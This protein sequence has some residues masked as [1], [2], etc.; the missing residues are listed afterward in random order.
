VGRGIVVIVLFLAAS[1]AHAGQHWGAPSRSCRGEGVLQ[2]SSVLWDIPWGKNWQEAC[3][4]TGAA[5]AGGRPP[6][7]CPQVV[8]QYGEWDTFGCDRYLEYRVCNGLTCT[9]RICRYAT[10]SV[11]HNTYAC[12][13]VLGPVCSSP[14]PSSATVQFLMDPP[15]HLVGEQQWGCVAGTTAVF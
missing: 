10:G 4:E 6:D 2:L 7:R 14:G 5:W 15:A 11:Y 8:F 13:F 9:Q 1:A 12:P 3:H